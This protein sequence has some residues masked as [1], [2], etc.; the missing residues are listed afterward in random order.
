MLLDWHCVGWAAGIA[1]RLFLRLLP[2]GLE[3]LE[4][5][6]HFGGIE[7]VGL[8]KDQDLVVLLSQNLDRGG[9]FERRRGFLEE[10]CGLATCSCPI[11][12]VVS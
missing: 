9:K 12:A 7:D 4:D 1:V 11:R 2:V 3:P 8:A 10:A 6:V 5:A